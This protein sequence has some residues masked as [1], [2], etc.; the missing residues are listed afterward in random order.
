MHYRALTLTL[1]L[2]TPPL[3]AAEG[4]FGPGARYS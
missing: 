1:L 3:L 2:L 4:G